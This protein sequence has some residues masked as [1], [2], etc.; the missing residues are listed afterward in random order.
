MALQTTK[1]LV[2]FGNVFE[3][4]LLDVGFSRILVLADEFEM[5]AVYNVSVSLFEL[6]ANCLVQSRTNNGE[7]S[8]FMVTAY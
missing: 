8:V 7:V 4:Q 6:A 1:R 5:M 3:D 2:I